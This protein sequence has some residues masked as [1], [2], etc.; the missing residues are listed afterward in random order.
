MM[1]LGV[2]N[3]L[4]FKCWRKAAYN[5]SCGIEENMVNAK[6]FQELEE[7]KHGQDKHLIN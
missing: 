6:I 1:H 7:R 3:I 4:Q 5:E 2:L